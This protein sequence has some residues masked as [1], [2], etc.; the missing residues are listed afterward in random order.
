M[1]PRDDLAAPP[2]V[3]RKHDRA[4]RRLPLDRALLELHAVIDAA[5]RAGPGYGCVEWYFYEERTEP[6]RRAL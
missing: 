3:A 6:Q 5:Q 2:R 1:Q 4:A